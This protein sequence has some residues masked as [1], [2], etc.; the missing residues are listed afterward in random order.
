MKKYEGYTDE[1]LIRCLREGETEI[2]DFLMEKYKPLVRKKANA[3]F[4]IGGE[5]ED[6]IQEGMIGLFKALRDFREEEESSFFHFAELCISR[7]MY[8]AT[9]ASNRQ[10]NQPLNTYISFFESTEGGTTWEDLLADE[11]TNPE[12]FVVEQVYFRTFLEELKKNLSR[13]EQEVLQLYLEGKNYVQIARLLEKPPKTIDNALQRIRRKIRLL[14]E[15][16][17]E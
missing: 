17:G 8:T 5:T 12:G 4:L 16:A 11:A 1:Q 2:T 13:M 7:Q 6:L 9:T 15:K 3:L 14:G 10:K